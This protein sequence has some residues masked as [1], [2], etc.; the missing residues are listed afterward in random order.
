MS[1]EPKVTRYRSS[2]TIHGQKREGILVEERVTLENESDIEA[3]LEDL[4]RPMREH[5]ESTVARL[6][7]EAKQCAQLHGHSSTLDFRESDGQTG[8]VGEI[9]LYAEPC[10]KLAFAYKMEG[11]A[12]QFRHCQQLLDDQDLSPELEEMMYRLANALAA[13]VNG[14]RLLHIAELERKAMSGRGL[15]KKK[16]GKPEV[17][18]L[19]AV[20]RFHELTKEQPSMLI[21]K[22]RNTVGAEFGVSGKTIGRW[23]AKHS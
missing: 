20:Y 23:V 16:N 13:T 2:Q 22:R 14:Q 5:V 17:I 1:K 9:G 10:S 19:E 18:E 21:T 7:T 8:A 6:T 11:S 12:R 4:S 15:L 3:Y